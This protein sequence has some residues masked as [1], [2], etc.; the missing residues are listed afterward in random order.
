MKDNKNIPQ[1]IAIIMDGN[2]RW[3][4]SRGLPKIAGHRQG[5]KAAQGII[6]AAGELGVKV[7]TLYTFSSENWKRPRHEVDALFKMLEEYLTKEEE[8]LNKNNIKL[9]V[10]GNMEAIPPSVRE[11]LKKVTE[12]TASNTGLVLNLAINYG[13]RPEIV[14]AVRKIAKESREGRLD[15]E[16]IDEKIFAGYL[17]T[18]HLPDPDLLV[19]TSGEYRISNFLLWQISYSELYIT[20]KLWPD[21]KK[22]DLKKAINAYRKRDRRFGG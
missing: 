22:E 3:A 19:R 9:S 11:K 1:H 8:K 13:G 17:Y 20:K 18:S 15:P 10:I 7:L 21:F 14:N 5:V 12:S 6:K 4:K 2:G 16:T